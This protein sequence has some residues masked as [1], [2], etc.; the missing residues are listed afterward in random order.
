MSTTENETGTQPETK[1]RDLKAWL[2]R[3]LTV[4][5]PTYAFVAA[6]AVVLALILIAID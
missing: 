3:P 2:T 4:T 5:G 1:A 6:G